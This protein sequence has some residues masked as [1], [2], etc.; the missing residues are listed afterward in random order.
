MCA[1][2]GRAPSVAPG[3]DHGALTPRTD[4]EGNGLS[5]DEKEA[6]VK[7]GE[8]TTAA[9]AP[10]NATVAVCVVPDQ[11]RHQRTVSVRIFQL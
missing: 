5:K 3:A 10:L 1:C 7:L 6:Y 9:L 11:C 8:E 4:F 2:V